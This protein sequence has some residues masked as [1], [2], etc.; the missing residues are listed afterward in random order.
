MK[1]GWKGTRLKRSWRTKSQRASN[2]SARRLDSVLRVGVKFCFVLLPSFFL[3]HS[4]L[5]PSLIVFMSVFWD[6]SPS[7]FGTEGSEAGEEHDL[8]CFRI[9]FLSA[10]GEQVRVRNPTSCASDSLFSL[11]QGRVELQRWQWRQGDQGGGRGWLEP[12]WWWGKGR[13]IEEGPIL[14]TISW[15]LIYCLINDWMNENPSNHLGWL[16]E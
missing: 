7:R 16:D 2:A 5:I 14:C 4:V 10:P 8:L 11:L 1:R 12:W 9:I 13:T 6:I 3:S 15:Q